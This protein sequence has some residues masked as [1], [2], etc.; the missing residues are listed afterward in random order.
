METEIGT[1]ID[2]STTSKFPDKVL[3]RDS[4]PISKLIQDEEDEQNAYME[5]MY[6]QQQLE[7]EQQQQ[8]QQQQYYNQ[9]MY[10]QQPP[11]QIVYQPAQKVDLFAS[12]DKTVYI[13]AF[14][15]F[16]LGY[17]IGKSFQ[18]LIIRPG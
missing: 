6:Q 8:Q 14:I 12:L 15:V 18:P 5:Q 9:P 13:I 7:L 11:P 4:T 10:Y 1:P 16:I 2:F 17:F 3:E